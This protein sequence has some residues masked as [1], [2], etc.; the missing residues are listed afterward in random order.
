M[1]KKAMAEFMRFINQAAQHLERFPEVNRI[2]LTK[3]ENR[4]LPE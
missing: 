4:Y 1:D 3:P 2:T